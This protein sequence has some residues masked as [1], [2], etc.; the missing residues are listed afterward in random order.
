MDP[1]EIMGIHDVERYELVK[2][3]GSGN[4]GVA[5]LMRDKKT[6]ELVAVKYIERGEKID[7]N[8]QREIINHR[9]LR[10]P[11]IVRF[12]EVNFPPTRP[13]M[14]SENPF[15]A[16]LCFACIREASLPTHP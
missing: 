8:V 10:H 15:F 4:F 5:R 7:E 2:D 3:I 9:S 12:K 11:N 1:L 6:R 13:P 14:I 16:F